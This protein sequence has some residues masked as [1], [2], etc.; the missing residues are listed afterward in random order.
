MRAFPRPIANKT[1]VIYHCVIDFK[2]V[3]SLPLMRNLGKHMCKC[4]AIIETIAVISNLLVDIL[5][6][7]LFILFNYIFCY[8]IHTELLSYYLVTH[9][10][11]YLAWSWRC[12][13]AYPLGQLFLPSAVEAPLA[14]QNNPWSQWGYHTVNKV[15]N[16]CWQN[17]G[18]TA[19]EQ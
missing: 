10:R 1:W 18:M 8:E 7:G 15:N 19:H 5:S 17:S 6:K 2:D 14:G 11:S 16:V 4:K 13:P 9:P 12:T 3:R